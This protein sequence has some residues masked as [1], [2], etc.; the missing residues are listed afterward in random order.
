M[1][2]INELRKAGVRVYIDQSILIFER[3]LEYDRRVVDELIGQIVARPDQARD[4]LAYLDKYWV[5]VSLCQR[6]AEAASFGNVW[7]QDLAI[8]RRTHHRV[9]NPSQLDIDAGYVVVFPTPASL[10]A[11]AEDY[12]GPVPVC[13]I[14]TENGYLYPEG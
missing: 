6:L 5:P 4:Y 2:A 12:P 14:S 11:S 10:W 3:P 1:H 9:N 8:D 7:P 13:R